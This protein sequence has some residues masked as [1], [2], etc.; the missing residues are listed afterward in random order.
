MSKASSLPPVQYDTILMGG[1]LDLIT[2]FANLKPGVVRAGMNFECSTTGG[3]TRIAGYERFDGHASPSSASFQILTVNNNALPNPGVTVTGATSGATGYLVDRTVGTFILTKV[4]GTFNGTENLTVSGVTVATQTGF[5]ATTDQKLYAQYKAM[6]ADVYRAAIA[7]PAGSGPV[8][9]AFLYNNTTYCF[10]DNAGGTA[11]VMYKATA[12]GWSAVPFGYEMSFGPRNATVTIT[13]AAPGVVTWN[14]HGLA[15]GAMVAFSTTGALPTGLS[16]G[17]V[18]YVVSATTNTFS[19]AATSGGTAI[20]T[21]GSQSGTHICAA[22][23]TQIADGVTVTGA[24]SGA[25]AVVARTVL[26][27]GAWS[28]INT[29]GRL[30]FNSITGTFANGEALTVGGVVYAQTSSAATQITMAPGGMFETTQTNFAGQANSVRV[31]GVDGKNRAW[32][33]DGTVFVPITTGTSPDTPTH[34]AAHKKH[35]FLSFRSSV[36]HSA[37]GLP[38]DYTAADGS[39][40]IA[41]GDIVTGMLELPGNQTTGALCVFNQINTNMLYG[42]SVNN[43]NFVP[44]NTGTGCMPNCSENMAQSFL[45][46]SRGVFTLDTTLNYGNFD[47]ASLTANIRPFIDANRALV[48]NSCLCRTK[49]QYRLFFSNG[50]ALYIT[51]VDGQFMGAMPMWL[52]ISGG[53]YN[54]WAGVDSYGNEV[55][56]YCGGDGMLYQAEKGTSFDGAAI[57][58]NITLVFDSASSPRVLKRY[59]KAAAEI[60]GTSYVNLAFYYTLGYGSQQYAPVLPDNVGLSLL[61]SNWDASNWDSFVWDGVSSLPMECE[62]VGTAENVA[63][64]FASSNNYTDPFTINSVVIHHTPRRGLR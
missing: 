31:Y 25:S 30:I 55:I 9:G 3:Y 57:P 26:Q 15:N 21:T 53:V 1:G 37:P 34:V 38:Y 12:S 59:R 2:P 20:T 10:R 14:G 43:W 63:L 22:Y 60:V 24:T 40:E 44:F 5:T 62:M 28:A 27:S 64:T 17:T 46:D 7:A 39:S 35:L 29:A 45:F 52:P 48:T 4:T 6:A 49:S 23:T 61:T 19:V 42:T 56:Y 36:I 11:S 33:F 47:Q 41:T 50:N 54:T 8:R 58:A 51:M 13:I 18:Y 16:A 32:E